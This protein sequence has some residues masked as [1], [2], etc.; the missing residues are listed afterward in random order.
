MKIFK[1]I[2]L[3]LLVLIIVV[4]GVIYFWLRS[5]APDY[6][7]NVH[8]KGLQDQV[9]VVYDHY[10]VPHVYAQN[11]HD[12]YFAF[13]YVHAQDRLFQMAMLRRVMEGRLSEI[14][15]KN[16]VEDD[17]YMRT[18]SI[19]KMAQ[20]WA[21][22]FMKNADQ[23]VKDEV[24]AYLD[25][26]NSFIENHKLPVEFTLLNFKPA[27]FTVK[28]VF[29]IIGYMALT[30]TDALAENPVAS[31]IYDK[32]GPAYLKDLGLDSISNTEYYHH[33]KDII[34]SGLFKNVRSLQDLTPMPIWEGSN[35]WVV[36][37]KHSKSGK[38]LLANDTHIKYSQP[39]V[40]YEAYLQ[41]PGFD[42]YGYYLAGI[43]FAL[44]GH[45]D[46]Y[47][48][49]LTIFPFDNLDLYAEKVNPADSNQVWHDGAWQNDSIDHQIIK[50]K[51]EK[52]IPF[53]IRYTV[54]GPILNGAFKN[55]THKS[56]QEVSMWWSPLHMNST[57]LQALYD[58]NNAVDMADFK[59]GVSLIDVVGLN[60][61][62][63]DTDG[64]IAW[65]GAGKIP[66]RKDS[67]VNP[68]LILNGTNPANDVI[69]FYPFDKNPQSVNPPSGILNTSNNM[70]PAVDGYIY[71]G[72]YYPGYRAARVRQMLESKPKWTIQEMEKI[73]LDTHSDRDLKLTQLILTH[74]GGTPSDPKVVNALENWDGNYDTA[75][76]GATIYTQLIYFVLRDAMMDETGPQDF[77]KLCGLNLL[78]S[79][80]ERLLEDSTS[81]WWDNVNTKAKETRADI[82]KQA[83]S[84]TVTALRNQLG[85]DVSTWKWGKVHQLMNVHPIGTRPPFDRLFNVGPFPIQG[86]NE[87]VDKEAFAYNEHG[88]YPV[89]SGPALRFLI[90]FANTDHA[91]SI[92]PT[93][94][95]GNFLS[96]HY[97]DQ[98]IMYVKGE[99]RP[100]ITLRQDIKNGTVLTLIPK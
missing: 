21:D 13:G 95:S 68:K 87:V 54:H 44:V 9:S 53:D 64:N 36:S 49:G 63:G 79:S 52:D 60:V 10:G 12:A 31:R 57:S 98:A 25:G 17:E 67:L 100:Q 97:A 6:S 34:L 91:L 51:G 26:I 37:G 66:Q 89:T 88:V 8:I 46:H 41:Y 43:P 93:G 3:A 30:F 16:F 58:M 14:L 48:W 96:P 61:A 47:G 56:D 86:S 28:D 74:M 23:P 71:P 70:P 55:V 18:L 2:L 75:S 33:S 11:A 40:W 82:F 69:G 84:E 45:N 22:A 99:Y 78:H 24:Q 7:G 80:I 73:Q 5:T 85:N 65:W 62:Y 39:A 35:N 83:F 90:D 42:M 81:V 72:Y 20:Q 92:I 4:G 76:V 77:K 1:R 94:Q 38:V 32:W 19:N 27:K 59:K 15:G 29:G 50:V